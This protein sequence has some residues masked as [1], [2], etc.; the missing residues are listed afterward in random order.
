MVERGVSK[1]PPIQR[2]V[3]VG[4]VGGFLGGFE[5]GEVWGDEVEGA[6]VGGGWGGEVGGHD[7]VGS[8]GR[9]WVEMC[10]WGSRRSRVF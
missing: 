10:L 6:E 8:W 1:R 2:R 5:G 3:L 7:E 4:F 9:Y